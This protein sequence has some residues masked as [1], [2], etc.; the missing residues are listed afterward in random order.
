MKKETKEKRLSVITGT[1]ASAL[2]KLSPYI[3]YYMLWQCKKHKI[4][5]EIDDNERMKW[6]NIFEEAIAEHSMKKVEVKHT[7]RPYQTLPISSYNTFMESRHYGD[8]FF[9]Y[10]M[11]GASVDFIGISLPQKADVDVAD[12]ALFECKSVEENMFKQNWKDGVPFHIQIQAQMQLYVTGLSKCYVCCFTGVDNPVKI[13]KIEPNDRV[14]NAIIDKTNDFYKSI[15]DNDEPSIESENDFQ[16]RKKYIDNQA[17]K[18]SHIDMSDE[19]EL[20]EK[21][22]LHKTI[23]GEIKSKKIELAIINGEI[24]DF[25]K[26]YEKVTTNIATISAPVI[27][28]KEVP[29]T[30]K[31]AHIKKGYRRFTIFHKKEK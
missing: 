12:L 13:Y 27:P 11:L 30:V 5:P 8:R 31:K 25:I 2:F 20:E 29:E 4:I 9:K 14:I 10:G 3:S 19:V 1:E 6:G 23:T 17:R 21:I 24:L 26:D 22:K 7:H 16:F 28:D 15:K 18:D